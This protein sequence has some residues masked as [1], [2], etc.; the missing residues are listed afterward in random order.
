MPLSSTAQPIRLQLIEKRERA[1]SALI[2]ATD[3]ASVPYR[4]GATV[5][6]VLGAVLG[7]VAAGAASRLR[8]TWKIKPYQVP[9]SPTLALVS[10]NS[11]WRRMISRTA[12]TPSS[13]MLVRPS[14]STA[15]PSVAGAGKAG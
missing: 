10:A 11:P 14:A 3:S 7:G 9:R 1:A 13:R 12:S 2:A 5:P 15:A 4:L 6:T 8:L